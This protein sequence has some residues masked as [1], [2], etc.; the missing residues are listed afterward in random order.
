[1]G[2]CCPCDGPT[3]KGSKLAELAEFT[4]GDWAKLAEF[5]WAAEGDTKE[6]EEGRE[7]GDQRSTALPPPLA[8]RTCCGAKG[9]E[10]GRGRGG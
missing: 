6:E 9:I 1:M 7:G 8:P 5:D 4:D 10:G 2:P 3:P